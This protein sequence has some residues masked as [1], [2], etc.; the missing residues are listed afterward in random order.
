MPYRKKKRTAV[1][2]EAKAAQVSIEKGGEGRVETD[3]SIILSVMRGGRPK[4]G[5]ERRREIRMVGVKSVGWMGV[6]GGGWD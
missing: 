4:Q 5:L 1:Q 2:K 3:I 6:V